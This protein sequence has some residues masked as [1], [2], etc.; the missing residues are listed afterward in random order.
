M[1][2]ICNETHKEGGKCGL[3]SRQK[4]SID[5][6]QEMA[7]RLELLERDIEISDKNANRSKGKCG[8]H[9]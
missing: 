9:T 2:H 7:Q 3:W 8:Q 1:C 5:E 4:V 6:D